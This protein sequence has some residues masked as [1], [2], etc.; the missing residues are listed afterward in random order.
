MNWASSLL[1]PVA[2][3]ERRQTLL[4][5]LYQRRAVALPK[6]KFGRVTQG[7]VMGKPYHSEL[8][9][10]PATINWALEQD[11]RDLRHTLL[12]KFGGL[13]LVAVG[14]GGS[15]VAATFAALLHET[16]TGRLARASTPLEAITRSPL[17]DTAALL[18]SARGTN[19]DI[20]KAA[21]LL[22][23]L[24]YDFISALTTRKG[25]QL[26]KLL[27]D[28]G[29]TVHE[30][31]VPT[32]RDGFLATNS[33]MATLVLLCR[34]AAPEGWPVSDDLSNSMN[35]KPSYTG[36]D[37]V[38]DKRT[39][40]ALA[41]GW[42][43]PA[44]IDMETRFSEAAIANVSVSDPRNFAH[45]RHNWLSFHAEHTGIVSLETKDSEPEAT[46]M[47]RFLPK[48][49]DIL[50]VNS[51]HEGPVATIEL[52]RAVME[53]TGKVAD[54]KGM[55][56]GRPTVP[57]FGRRLYRAGTSR[58]AGLK[59]STPIEKKRRA[60]FLGPSADYN[61]I[62]AA[63]RKF[64]DRLQRTPFSS[65]AVDYDGTLCGIDHRF[66]PLSSEISI[67]LNR[68]LREGIVLG[69]ASGRG[70]SVY[71]R[72]RES[73]CT[74]YWNNV[75]VG[76]YNGATV[77]TLFEE[78]PES[79]AEIKSPLA[80]THARLRRLEKTIG[81]ESETRPNQISL[82]PV[83]DGSSP[84]DLRTV[85]MEQLA[86]I[87]DVS[88]IASSHSVDIIPVSTSKTAVVDALQTIRSGCVLRI[89][90]QGAAGGNDFDLLNA[91]LSL[92]VDRVSSNLETCWNLG[93]PGTSGPALTLQYLRALRGGPDVFRLDTDS[94]T[95][96]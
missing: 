82:R 27:R 42:A 35:S 79:S 52:V 37:S 80:A 32:G 50:R 21:E 43:M 25:T 17:R 12:R 73:I 70:R 46:R 14:S 76:L 71:E 49:I 89:G 78:L 66:E 44:A 64:E 18:L 2:R 7:I 72:L 96:T 55:D 94:L 51:F 11:I 92:S 4:G 34:A 45:G 26:G 5:C 23:R 69:V 95:V 8:N 62:A 87:E 38:L 90:D 77:I 10:I 29:A 39:I 22:P 63:L 48:D 33:L 13:N 60:L 24:G 36:D 20:R 1:G 75:L 6:S 31:A 61:Q 47:L 85:V 74:D 57:I 9:K 15:L 81:F 40:V 58:Y 86:G 91:G 16:A 84:L 54:S 93:A 41:Q 28:Y 65:L 53:L 68:L 19:A 3:E 56:P 59:E 30:F 83:A 67:E 88:V